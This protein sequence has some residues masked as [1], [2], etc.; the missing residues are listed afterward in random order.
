LQIC[1][2]HWKEIEGNVFKS[3]LFVAYR[4][5]VGR[6]LVVPVSTFTP[7]MYIKEKRMCILRLGGETLVKRNMKLDQNNAQD[8]GTPR[9]YVHS[10]LVT[11]H[12]AFPRS[13]ED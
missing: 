3:A 7:C 13:F 10:S 1:F 12:A 2:R 4:C 9:M 5:T 6:R 11:S 8:I